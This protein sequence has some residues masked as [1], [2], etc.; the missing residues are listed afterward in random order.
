[1][2]TPDTYKCSCQNCYEHLEYPVDYEGTEIAC[3]HCGQGTLLQQ[4]GAAV[5]RP[6]SSTSTAPAPPAMGSHG[7]ASDMPL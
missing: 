1:M 2:T 3:P 5:T 4:S 6:S 7:R